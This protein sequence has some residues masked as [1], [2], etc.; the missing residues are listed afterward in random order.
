[1]IRYKA[2]FFVSEF[3]ISGVDCIYMYSKYACIHVHTCICCKMDTVDEIRRLEVSDEYLEW[4][5][6]IRTNNIDGVV[7]LGY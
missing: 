6:S 5:Q 2:K 1:M 3:V 7:E 4:W